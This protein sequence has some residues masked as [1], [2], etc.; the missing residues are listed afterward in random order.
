MPLKLNVV[1]ASTR[2]GRVGVHV[3]QWL[4]GVAEQH[5]AFEAEWVDLKDVGLPLYDEP[6]HP[7]LR[8]YEHE[9]TKRWSAIVDAAD[10]YVFVMPEYNYSPTPALTNALDFVFNEWAY[11]PLGLVSYG[12]VS[13]GLRAAQAVKMTAQALKLVAIPEGVVVPFVSQQIEDGVFSAQRRPGGGG[14]RDAR[15]TGALGRGAEAAAQLM[16]RARRSAVSKAADGFWTQT[17]RGNQMSARP[18]P[19]GRTEAMACTR[20]PRSYGL[21]TT[22]TASIPA[23]ISGPSP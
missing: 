1:V 18:K 19:G 2:P 21:R 3:A 20:A 8:Q 9:H 14:A 22:G 17:G 23:G 5:P 13:G 7:R 4:Y 6:K 15:R 10:A 16:L 12:G 11:K